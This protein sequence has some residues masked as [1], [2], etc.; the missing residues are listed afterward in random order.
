MSELERRTGRRISPR[1]LIFQ[2]LEQVAAAFDDAE[3]A[4]LAA[5]TASPAPAEVRPGRGG[6]LGA[7]RGLVAGQRGDA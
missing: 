4:P 1:D 3:A 2:T 5:G 6:L 7:L